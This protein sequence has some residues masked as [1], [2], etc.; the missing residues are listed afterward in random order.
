MPYA[1]RYTVISFFLY[2]LSLVFLSFFLFPFGRSVRFVGVVGFY[3]VSHLFAS[4]ALTR[5]QT[6]K[7]LQNGDDDYCKQHVPCFNSHSH[8]ISHTHSFSHTNTNTHI[9][10]HTE[11]KMPYTHFC[12]RYLSYRNA[13][14][15]TLSQLT[16]GSFALSERVYGVNMSLTLSHSTHTLRRNVA[17]AHAHR[18]HSPL[19]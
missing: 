2:F 11:E 6:T 1:L 12:I 4:L 7:R 5:T 16:N 3:F 18:T 8:S 13:T 17:T 10:M 14:A 9:Y 19:Q 15:Y